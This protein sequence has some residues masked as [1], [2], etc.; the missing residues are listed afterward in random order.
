MTEFFTDVTGPIPYL[1][2]NSDE[3]LSFRWYDKDRLVAGKRME[4]HLRFAVC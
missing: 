3:A 4:D 1:G 2:P